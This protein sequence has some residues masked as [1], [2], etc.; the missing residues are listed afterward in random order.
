MDYCHERTS[1]SFD[2]RKSGAFKVTPKAIVMLG[3]STLRGWSGYAFQPC[4]ISLQ[5]LHGTLTKV[6]TEKSTSSF[7]IF[8]KSF[9]IRYLL[10]GELKWLKCRYYG[11][12]CQISWMPAR[13]LYASSIYVHIYTALCS[14]GSYVEGHTNTSYTKNLPRLFNPFRILDRV[15]SSP[16]SSA[17]PLGSA[18]P[19]VELFESSLSHQGT[20]LWL[21]PSNGEPTSQKQ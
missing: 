19:K 7:L 16:S 13:N 8:D 10:C 12:I 2:Q 3:C 11:Y 9:H 4:D 17:T 20:T 21:E 15:L 6:P 18:K 1:N 5:L 14:F